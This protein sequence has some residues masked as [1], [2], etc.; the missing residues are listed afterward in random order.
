[1]ARKGAAERTTILKEKLEGEEDLPEGQEI[2]APDQALQDYLKGI[3]EDN[4]SVKIFKQKVGTSKYSY[5]GETTVDLA[6]EAFI[7]KNFG[8]GKYQIRCF[9]E[10]KFKGARTIEIEQGIKNPEEEDSG[11]VF[12][13]SPAA[14]LDPMTLQLEMI[15]E[16]ART[17]REI[18]LKMLD[19]NTGDRTSAMELAQV[20]AM[21]NS[22]KP[23]QSEGAS[24]MKMFSEMVPFIREMMKLMGG[25]PPEPEEGGWLGI[26][27]KVITQ[28]P[29]IMKIFRSNPAPL[30]SAEPEN[31]NTPAIA[32]QAAALMLP[33][34]MVKQL[35]W[36]FSLL[37]NRAA[38]NAD[39][40]TFVDL[41]MNTLDIQQT[42][43]I[44][45]LLDKPYEEIAALDA[46]LLTPLYRPWFETFF[47]ELKNAIIERNTAGGSESDGADAGSD[48]RVVHPVGT[49]RP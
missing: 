29:D 45:S 13:P 19:R 37:K 3:G 31:G 9:Y 22:M 32:P 49:K 43:V 23:A 2:S 10:G 44:I 8:E 47:R 36:V 28:V 41:A 35:Q 34:E 6:D 5:C 30:Q 26:A 24:P 16:D 14:S 15:R 17:N 46:E 1:M 27:N 7:Q 25:N 18:L 4:L 38:V 48:E 39:P 20:M 42:Q 11:P 12:L 33:P 40:L 21:L